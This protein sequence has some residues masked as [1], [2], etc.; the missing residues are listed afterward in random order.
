MK[1]RKSTNTT[2]IVT[3]A[4][5]IV[6][7]GFS[8]ATMASGEDHNFTMATESGDR[9]SAQGKA[10][11]RVAELVE[12]ESEGRITI[13]VFYQD[14]IGGPQELFDQLVRGN[15]DLMLTWPHTSYDER[16]GVLHLPYLSL[17]WDEALE[18]YGRDGWL[19]EI[20]EPIFSD[21]GLEYLG[22]F[23]EGFGGIATRDTYATSYDEAREEGIKVRSQPIF[24]LPQTVEAMGFQ[25]V[26]IDWSEVY[27]SIQ[28]GVVDGDSSNVIFWDYTYFND[29][30]DYFVHSKHNFSFYSFL[31]NQDAWQALDEEDRGIIA[32]AV[33]IVVNEQFENARKEDEK[34]I[35][36]AQEEG[37]EYIVPSDEEMA[38]W[39]ERVRDEVWN[40]AEESLGQEVMDAVRANATEPQE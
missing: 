10:I 31:M 17:G 15:I 34:W 19:S 28:T 8:S 39:I 38:G 6:L 26:P 1:I 13:N 40:E 24:P 37:M 9:E 20:I 25:A 18:T 7:L 22:P 33:D 16:L 29:L 2:S 36:K 5:M 11:A 27:T 21:I 14:E 30:L 23:P 3:A 35:Q 32:D 12:E 4:S